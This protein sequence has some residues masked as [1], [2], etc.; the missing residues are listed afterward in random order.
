MSALVD[1]VGGPNDK[2][3][4]LIRESGRIPDSGGLDSVLSSISGYSGKLHTGPE[5]SQWV[6]KAALQTADPRSAL[7]RTAR[8]LSGIDDPNFYSLLEDPDGIRCLMVILGYSN[9][10]SSLIMRSPADY[11]WLMREVGLADSRSLADMRL[12]L[13]TAS[14]RE[15]NQEETAEL[16]RANK[17]REMLRIGVRDLLGSATLG[18]TISDISHLAEASIDIAVES[19]YREL[20]EKHGVPIHTTAEGLNRPCRFS[21]LGMGKLGGEELNYSS[22]IDLYYLYSSHVGMTTG[23]PAPSGGYRDAIENHR[24]FVRMGEIVTK[25]LNERTSSGIVFRVDLRLRPEGDSGEIAYSIPS[26]DV[27][28]QSWG[29]TVDRLALLKARP[30]GG[31]RRVGEEFLEHMGPFIYRRHLDYDTLEEIG[32]LKDRID[33]HTREDARGV[34][35]VKLGRGG[36][37]EIEFIIQTLQLIHGGRTSAVRERNSLRALDRL[38]ENGFITERDAEALR[39]AYTFLRNVEHRIQLVEERQTQLLP[40]SDED[41]V[42]LVWSMGFVGD[43]SPDTARFLETFDSLTGQVAEQFNRLFHR[44]SVPVPEGA[45]EHDDLLDEELSREKAVEK[46]A[47]AGFKDP[48]S[49]YDNLVLLRDGPPYG[50]FSDTCRNL[51]RQIAPVLLAHMG[52]V[53]DPD[54]VLVNLERFISRVGAR[55]SYYSMLAANPEAARLLVVLFGSSPFLSALV[56][57]QPDLLD[58]IVAGTDLAAVKPR[59]EIVEEVRGLMVSSPSLEDELMVLRR[60]RNGEVLRLGLGDLLGV[61][62]LPVI[63]AEL[64]GLA[65]VLLDASWRI[66]V[67]EAGGGEELSAGSF[68]V[69]AMG[70]AGGREMNYSSDLDM[71]FIYD[72]GAGDGIGGSREHY[73]RVAQ[74]MITVLT[75]P[76]AEGVLY[77]IDMRLRPSGQ[78]GPLVT[79]LE[80]FERYHREGAMVWEQQAMTKA[81]WICGDDRFRER[82]ENVIEELAFGRPLTSRGLEEIVRVR[83]RMEEEIGQEAGGQHYDIKA[84]PGGLVDVEFAVQILQLTYGHAY[85]SLRTPTTMKALETLWKTGLVDENQYNVWRRAYRFF[86]E[87]E[88]GSQLYQD[89]SDPRVP[90]DEARALPMARRLGYEGAHGARR[91]L[92]EVVNTREKVRQEFNGIVAALRV[93]LGD[94]A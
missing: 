8:L 64:T 68:A 86:R 90:K 6:V 44:E 58:V 17:Y 13:L 57:R 5:F 25:L 93:K 41:L 82:V 29:R 47:A 15:L 12:D 26:L 67:R 19:A 76:T 24:F 1:A 30:V 66:A 62:E 80:A 27:Y 52:A 53:S 18:E 20:K 94:G 50:H 33:R 32:L 11:I 87:V 42:K 37:R 31:E 71:I 39:E 89:R 45:P 4:R 56:I 22:D 60:Y 73:T 92:D 83:A 54:A 78:A 46:L 70:K 2:L 91:F 69:V 21:V 61:K 3:L 7:N 43:G 88:N 36:I 40:R 9:F 28:Y 84:G 63:N 85:P 79:T 14:D 49:A 16:L 74:R 72:G 55:A 35:D 34:R 51:L 48:E 10:L 59:E 81:R 75:S 23:R 77:R 38:M 65:E